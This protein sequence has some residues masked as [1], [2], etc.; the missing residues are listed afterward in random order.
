MIP[1]CRP[2]L[3][4]NA[5]PSSSSCE[6]GGSTSQCL[7]KLQGLQSLTRRSRLSPATFYM[8]RA[9]LQALSYLSCAYRLLCLNQWIAR[10][11]WSRPE[12]SNCCKMDLSAT[13]AGPWNT[14]SKSIDRNEIHTLVRRE[15]SFLDSE[16]TARVRR[17]ERPLR[18]PKGPAENL[19]SSMAMQCRRLVLSGPVGAAGGRLPVL[20]SLL[21]RL[22]R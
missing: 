3:L 8:Q 15:E 17:R 1:H 22:C 9:H 21:D 14:D 20:L 19:P 11:I 10:G 18:F 7:N 6:Y 16:G 2:C 12:Y 4:S 13:P 5:R